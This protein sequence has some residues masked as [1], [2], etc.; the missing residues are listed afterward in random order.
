MIIGHDLMVQLFLV[1]NFRHR[2][3]E[4]DNAV[5]P[6]KD[7]GNFLDKPNLTKHDM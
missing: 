3:L 5:V 7:T 6:I 4:W 1:D 2:V